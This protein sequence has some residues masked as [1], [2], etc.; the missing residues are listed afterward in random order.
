MQLKDS[1]SYAAAE[2][3]LQK[4]IQLAPN[5]QAYAN[6]GWLYLDQKRYAQAAAATRQALELNDQDWRD[7]AN[8]PLPSTRLKDGERMRPPSAKKRSVLEREAVLKS[9]Q[10]PVQRILRI[11]YS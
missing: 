2:A 4:S 5:Y 3:A 8:L 10:G 11:V 6:L 9:H 7:W 1:E